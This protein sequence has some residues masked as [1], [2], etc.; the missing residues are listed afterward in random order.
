ML[1]DH[2]TN[3]DLVSGKG[4]SSNSS[5][6]PQIKYKA[7]MA[8]PGTAAQKVWTI[9]SG[10]EDEELEE[11]KIAFLKSLDRTSSKITEVTD[12]E[13]QEEPDKQDFWLED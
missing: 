6:Q 11:A 1:R 8:P 4:N 7:I 10:L 3:P 5:N 12:E 2:I 9:M 13:K